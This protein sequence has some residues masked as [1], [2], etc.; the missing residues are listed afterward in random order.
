MVVSE[1]PDSAPDKEDFRYL[2]D[3][4]SPLMPGL[5]SFD[6]FPRKLWYRTVARQ[7]RAGGLFQLTYPDPLGLPQLRQALASYLAVAR[8]IHCGPEQVVITAGY[9]G[10]LSLICR[11]ILKR[12]SRVWVE[13]PGYGFTTRAIQMVGGTAIPIPVDDEGLN[14]EEAIRIEPEADL[15]VV[16][17]SNQFPLGACLSPERRG[18]LLAW[19]AQ[20][21]SWIV[22]DDYAGEFRYDGWPL[23]ALKRLDSNDRVFYVGTFSKTM[24]PGLRIGY[25][26]VPRSQLSL[27]R[28]HVRR[29]DG[30]RSVLEQAALSDFV[31]HGHFGRHVKRMRGLYGKRSAA[32]MSA[33]TEVFGRRLSIR[34]SGGG[35]HLLARLDDDEDDI[36]MES[37]AGEAGLRPL[38]LSKMGQ[39]RSCGPGLILGFA[40]LPEEQAYRI[41]R[42]LRRAIGPGRR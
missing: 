4:P 33:V 28:D 9:L 21:G 1:E 19:A 35:L 39:G 27:I 22:E 16:A 26:V 37:A 23:P 12:G 24:F 3:S 18:A 25:L 15:C 36:E 20:A 30:G 41:V 34:L 7:A 2:F 32:L 17:P 38:A 6:Q 10:A 42:R 29:L 31:A 11:A 8:G 13:S 40:N 5:P 14:V